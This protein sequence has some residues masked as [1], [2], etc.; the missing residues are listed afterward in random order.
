MAQ[1]ALR[2]EGLSHSFGPRKALD[3]VSLTVPAGSFT[4][5]LG[6]NGAGKTTLFS[7]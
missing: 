5:L 2:I 4:A 3:R 7:W 6:L 1:P